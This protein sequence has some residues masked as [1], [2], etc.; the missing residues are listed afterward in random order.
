MSIQQKANMST[1]VLTKPYVPQNQ[2]TLVTFPVGALYLASYIVK[3]ASEVEVLISDPEISSKSFD[4]FVQD[5]VDKKPDIIGIT[6]FSH[7]IIACKKLIA[8]L[9]AKLP[10]T[11]IV[12]GGSHVN[13]VREKCMTQFTDID[14]AIY[15]EGEKGFY[16]LCRQLK[17]GQID[18]IKKIPGLIYRT[19][20]A[21]RINANQYSDDINEFDPLEYSLIEVE[22]YF[23]L[24][25][26][27][28]LFRVGDK[29]AQ[30]ITT[31]GCPYKCTFC[32]SPVNMGH[33][34]RQRTI[35][36]II[37]E[38]LELVK[39]GADEIHI[40]DD[41]FTFKREFVITLCQA[42]VE[43]D[44]LRKLHFCMPNGVRLDKLDPEM[45]KEMKKAGFYHMGV[46]IEVGSDEA[47]KIVRKN[48][49]WGMIKD[50]VKMIKK[51]GLTVTGF[52]IIGFPHDKLE[53]IRDT[54][55]APDNL[56]LDMASFG[57]FTPLPGT[58][59]FN[60]LVEKKEILPDFIPSF[61]SGKVTYAP[62][63]IS[64]DELAIIQ[65]N[66]VFRYWL[67]PKRLLLIF[68]RMKLRDISYAIRRL[69]IL[70]FRFR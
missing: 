30:I 18:D 68:K 25:S 35:P 58:Q 66:I 65:R 59:S 21:I 19:G 32:A 37:K 45:L 7:E 8:S 11:Q 13:G 55:K 27:M 61:A 53:S 3:H 15:G 2:R 23:K 38:L 46:G 57:N 36:Y 24:G 34:I 20:N 31:R 33:R 6:V 26:P 4:G 42:I 43:N 63:G 9:G 12:L 10:D 64:C 69:A 17:T 51:A 29:V 28:G 40:M 47:M 70:V 1:V 52:F 62:R 50:T 67:K 48:I 54:E 41:N 39:Y 14:Y 60:E 44:K 49:K 16:E 22:K 5:I 56:G